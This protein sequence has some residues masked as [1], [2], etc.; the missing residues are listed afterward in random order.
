MVEVSVGEFVTVGVKVLV[1]VAVIVGELVDV[2]VAV[3][4]DDAV[5]V[6]VA[7]PVKVLVK[8][9]VGAAGVAGP[10]LLQP[11]IKAA[12]SNVI[13]NKKPIIFFTF[14]SPKI[15]FESQCISEIQDRG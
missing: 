9:I 2:L 5:G 11:T 7:V 1:R 3:T 14:T 15:Y 13:A 8:V 10:A 6:L 4:V 12:G